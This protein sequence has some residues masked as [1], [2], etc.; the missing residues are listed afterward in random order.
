[1]GQLENPVSV[2]PAEAGVS[3]GRLGADVLIDTWFEDELTLNLRNRFLT[4][5]PLLEFGS[6]SRNDSR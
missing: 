3:V 4:P 5:V 6:V 1:M 2:G